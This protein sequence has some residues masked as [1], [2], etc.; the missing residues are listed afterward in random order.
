MRRREFIAGLAGAAAS[1]VLARAQG[2]RVRRVGVLMG[3]TEND[4][5][6]QANR[7]ALRE[8]LAKL[9]W[10]EGRNLRIDLRFGGDDA[11]RIHAYAEE[12]VGRSPDVI[13]TGSTPT[14]KA[15]QQQ[16]RTIPIGA[17]EL[18]NAEVATPTR[19]KAAEQRALMGGFCAL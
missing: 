17:D 8:G 12:L 6:A 19:K 4:H 1:P 5:L 3:G 7:L 11:D 13:V 10:V 9:G 18:L 2:E 14:T 15:V 16:T